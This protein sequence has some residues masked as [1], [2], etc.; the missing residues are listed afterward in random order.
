M[1]LPRVGT[2]AALLTV[3][4]LALAACGNDN[5]TGAADLGGGGRELTGTLN[6]SGAS[7]IE[8]AMT[9]WMAGYEARQPEVR[10][11][12]NPIGSG[13]GRTNLIAG[14]V[15][16]AG[17]D[18]ALHDDEREKVKQTCGPDGAMNLPVYVAPIAVP[19]NLKGVRKLQ[20][21]PATLA[22]I[23]NRKIT[24]WNA[25]EIAADNPGVTLPATRITVVNRSD[26]S[27]TTESFTEY[28]SEAGGADWPHEP[29]KSWP[30][31]GGE[32]A[33]Q[34]TGVI[35]VVSSTPG[36][37]GYADA[38]A[39][40]TLTHARIGVG[41]EF[42]EY[43]PEAAAKVVDASETVDTGVQGDLA[44]HIERNTTEPG[45]YPIVLV[46]YAIV[47]KQYKDQNT[48]DLVKDYIGY[49]ASAEGQKEAASA[50]GAAPISEDLQARI[51]SSL[52][53][54]TVESR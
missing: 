13:G 16:F 47:C 6:G 19:Y 18:A 46:S 43:S 14:A 53:T 26:E 8:S 28:L 7:S 27:G 11:N 37:I 38:S 52:E 54:I 31:A 17:S 24:T 29:D 10:V 2:A 20:L 9:A 4:C 48:A 32:A 35:D 21:K 23:F 45:T 25:P 3:A 40:G 12:Y 22:K 33:S 30:V 51:A 39:V 42:V 41:D 15:N 36:A 1:K 5:P 34:T 49:V 50:A 44:L